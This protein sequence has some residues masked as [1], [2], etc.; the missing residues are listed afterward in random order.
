MFPIQYILLILQIV[1]WSVDTWLTLEFNWIEFSN[2]ESSVLTII[3]FSKN[4][5][6]EPCFPIHT[7]SY[8][9]MIGPSIVKLDMIFCCHLMANYEL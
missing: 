6:F 2:S 7:F 5:R 9:L 3:G 1:K 8:K 4:L